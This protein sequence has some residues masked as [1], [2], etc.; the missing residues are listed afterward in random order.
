MVRRS[1]KKGGVTIFEERRKQ[2]QEELENVKQ[3]KAAKMALAQLEQKLTPL[4]SQNTN[5]NQSPLSVGLGRRKTRRG[6]KR[7]VTRR[8]K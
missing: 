1:A 7:S 2:R 4:S 3:S 6:K 5:P 8:R